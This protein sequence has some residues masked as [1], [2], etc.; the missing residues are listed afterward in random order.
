MALLPPPPREQP[1]V[2]KCIFVTRY[3]EQ[4]YLHNDPKGKPNSEIW[5]V[6][7]GEETWKAVGRRWCP[8]IKP[9]F[10]EEKKAYDSVLLEWIAEFDKKRSKY[11]FSMGRP[12][13]DFIIRL[14]LCT[15]KERPRKLVCNQTNSKPLKALKGRN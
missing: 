6:D 14:P 4:K 13:T 10:Y 15:G 9:A 7:A 12:M 2:Q 1:F 5:I 11:G 8:W 3:R